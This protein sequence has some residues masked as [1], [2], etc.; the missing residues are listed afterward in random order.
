MNAEEVVIL[1][2]IKED[3]AVVLADLKS[4]LEGVA[5]ELHSAQRRAFDNSD[6]VID[7][8]RRLMMVINRLTTQLERLP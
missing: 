6:F 8:F 1:H 2:A 4:T 7:E 5:V 3:A